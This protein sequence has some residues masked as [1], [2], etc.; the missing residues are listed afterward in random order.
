MVSIREVPVTASAT[1]PGAALLRGYTEAVNEVN[2]DVW[3][4]DDYARTAA[5]LLESSRPQPYETTIRLVA[6]ADDAPPDDE[7]RPEHVLGTGL[8][9]LPLQE[10]TA[11]AYVGVVVRPAHRREGIGG[12]LYDE[13]LRLARAH[14]RTTLMAE[15][16]HRAEPPEGPTAR[17][18]TTG[19]GRVPVDDAG[20]RFLAARGWALEQ[21]A[22]RSVLELP[23]DP[24]ALESFRADAA[25]AAGDAYRV[26]TWDEHV[27]DELVDQAAAL[28][29]EMS[30]AP[31]LG[32]LD[33]EQDV[34]DAKRVRTLEDTHDARG[35]RSWTVAVQHVATGRLAG[36]TT[37]EE[38]PPV[39]DLVHQEDTL[40]AE[41]H[42]GHRLGMLLKAV[43]L[44]RL[45]EVR[46]QARRIDTWNAEEND[47]MLAINIALGFR[48]AGCA[49]EWQLKIA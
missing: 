32:G 21:V 36:Y 41:G 1:E 2:R 37:L 12:A 30:V 14:G 28:Y 35:I 43:N 8:L 16:D 34:W 31:P 33:Y 42:R 46:P 20:V 22:R 13:V 10:N 45:A 39:R 6:V 25:R 40:V 7:V 17:S 48:P 19:S 11:W 26:V 9:F 5:E 23:V 44:Q 49:G 27:P 47:H 4:N 29:T 24:D 18:A 15:T 3:G 38:I